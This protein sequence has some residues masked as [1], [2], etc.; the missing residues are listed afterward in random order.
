MSQTKVIIFSLKSTLPMNSF[1]QG[2]PIR[3]QGAKLG[4][5]F[6]HFNPSS[7]LSFLHSSLWTVNPSV[8]LLYL[9]NIL[10]SLFNLRMEAP[11]EGH[12]SP[13]QMHHNNFLSGEG[14]LV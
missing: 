12:H 6:A 10:S 8:C 3:T 14:I 5:S 9:P 2:A 1:L 7:F 13:H 4:I 11:V